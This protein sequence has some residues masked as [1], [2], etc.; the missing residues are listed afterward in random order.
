MESERAVALARVAGESVT[1]DDDVH[2]GIA[3]RLMLSGSSPD[4]CATVMGI[5]RTRFDAW[6]QTYPRMALA[7]R[8]AIDADAM[9]IESVWEQAVGVVNPV[10]G[11]REASVEAGKFWLKNRKGWEDK[12]MPPDD[13]KGRGGQSELERLAEEFLNV[14]ERKAAVAREAVEPPSARIERK[15][16]DFEHSN[17]ELDIDFKDVPPAGKTG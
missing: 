17:F 6:C 14:L 4:E 16:R 13:R 7:H 2:P 3:F 9:V 15:T 1:Y 12:P 5:T 8:R 10:S 11:K